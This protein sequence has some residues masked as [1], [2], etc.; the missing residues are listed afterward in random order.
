MPFLS[1]IDLK[2]CYVCDHILVGQ[3]ILATILV[4]IPYRLLL[5]ESMGFS[6]GSDGKES[7]YDRRPGLD[8]WVA[9]IPW[10]RAWQPIPVF[11]PGESHG[12]RCLSSYSPWGCKESDMT[13]QL[14]TMQSNEIQTMMVK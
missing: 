11:L 8:P 2:L 13:E 5:E 12:Q 1:T 7:A 4:E 6:G 3:N 10:R 9:K 14:S